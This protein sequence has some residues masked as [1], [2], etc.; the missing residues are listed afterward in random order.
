ME[1]VDAA[2]TSAGLLPPVPRSGEGAFNRVA[3]MLEDP[4]SGLPSTA[5][6]SGWEVV[7]YRPRLGLD[8]LGQP[9]VGVSIGGG[10]FGSSGLYG[11]IFGLFSD[12]L[13]RHQV[14]AALQA[15]GQL[16]EI[17]FA[18]Q[19][20]NMRERWNFGGS[21][22]RIPIVYGGYREFIDQPNNEFIQSVARIRIFDSS[23]QGFAQY[24]FSLVR[25]AEFS[26]GL[27]RI[28][29][30]LQF[31]EWVYDLNT[32]APVDQRERTED[33]L[34]LNLFETT[35][36]LVYDNSL[37]GATSPFAGQR[38]RFQLSPTFGEL[39]YLQA[40]GDYRKYFFASPFTLAVRGMHM[41]RYG[42]DSDTMVDEQRVFQDAYLGQPWYVRGYN[43]VYN[44]CLD[45]GQGPDCDLLRN[46]LGSRITVANAEIRFP[47]LR[48]VVVGNSLGLPPIEGFLFA[49]A[50][51]AWDKDSSPTFSSGVPTDEDERGIITSAGVGARVNV[52][53]FVIVEVD[54]LR[55]FAREDGWR[56]NFSFVP[57]F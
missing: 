24:P 12:I 10:A 51:L 55:A 43:N 11:G 22:Q 52:L 4:S 47:L 56:W 27:R 7:P 57:G 50:G 5:E 45:S 6:A 31:R 25:R 53:G 44:R 13:G 28:A 18:V 37:L 36:A 34:S 49:D 30:D 16:D 15:Q 40:L 3:Q 46:L 32:G 20:L 2:V 14:F 42:R 48:Q 8:Y 26:A 17:G 1:S 9:Q 38:Y 39:Q 41:G 33:A 35:A 23:I 19:Y 29:R 21:A 54:Y